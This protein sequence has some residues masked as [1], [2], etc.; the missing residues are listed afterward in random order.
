MVKLCLNHRP[1]TASSANVPS[2]SRREGPPRGLSQ[3]YRGKTWPA[4]GRVG[5]SSQATKAVSKDPVASRPLHLWAESNHPSQGEIRILS[6][7]LSCY[8]HD[9]VSGVAF[10]SR[11]PFLFFSEF[12]VGTVGL[13]SAFLPLLFVFPVWP[14][15]PD[16]HALLF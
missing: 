4:T 1:V 8:L 12:L 14:D 9:T 5:I 16:A 7:L 15:L 10:L 13:I 11:V 2:G 6:C 3:K